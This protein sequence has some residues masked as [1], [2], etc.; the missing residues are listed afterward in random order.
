MNIAIIGGHD[1]N[2]LRIREVDVIQVSDD[3]EVE[4]LNCS[5]PQIE[6][7]FAQSAN[8]MFCGGFPVTAKCLRLETSSMVW[9]PHTPMLKKRLWHAMTTTTN[10]SVFVCGGVDGSK[11]ESSCEIFDG[12]WK[13]TKEFP[14]PISHHCM[15][16]TPNGIFSIGGLEGSKAWKLLKD[17]IILSFE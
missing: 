8:L 7:Y 15:V 17:N 10:G 3:G 5:I 11:R 1:D 14:A 4:R 6:P 16:A 12:K 2:E 9:K 13:F